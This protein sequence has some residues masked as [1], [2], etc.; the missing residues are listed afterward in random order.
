MVNHGSKSQQADAA[1]IGGANAPNVTNVPAV[2]KAFVIMSGIMLLIGVIVLTVMIM[3][4][5]G[6][7]D[8]GDQI[9]ASKPA[10]DLELPSGVKVQQVVADGKRLVLLAQ[11]QDGQQ[12]L[13]VVDAL[14]GARLSLIRVTSDK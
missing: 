3:L 11:G 13:A 5:A 14:S 7:S 6:A 12:Y 2:L 9:E 1:A 10:V 8:D 4:K